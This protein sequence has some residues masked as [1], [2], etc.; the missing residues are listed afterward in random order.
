MTTVNW[1]TARSPGDALRR[2]AVVLLATT[3]MIITAVALSAS[4]GAAKP[5]GPHPAGGYSSAGAALQAAARASSSVPQLTLANVVVTD[6]ATGNANV[7]S[8]D[9]PAP[10]YQGSNPT[11][12][13]CSA[14]PNAYICMAFGSGVANKDGGYF[15][16]FGGAPYK[17]GSTFT[18]SSASIGVSAQGTTCDINQPGY[19]ASAQRPH[20]TATGTGSSPPTAGSSTMAPPAS[21]AASV[22]LVSRTPPG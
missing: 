1:C 19:S 13:P 16:I 10:V 18:D 8:Y 6:L 20:P 7:Y 4:A 3:C 9:N 14:D 15:F 2:F 22:E 21:Q 12:A 17:A 5:Y 11:G